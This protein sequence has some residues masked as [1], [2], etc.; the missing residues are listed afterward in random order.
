LSHRHHQR[1]VEQIWVIPEVHTA[2]AWGG[3]WSGL[4]EEAVDLRDG[5][6]G[7]HTIGILVW[8]DVLDRWVVWLWQIGRCKEPI[9]LWLDGKRASE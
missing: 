3:T 5:V 6:T 2:L 7:N 8:E 1:T 9:E 4:A